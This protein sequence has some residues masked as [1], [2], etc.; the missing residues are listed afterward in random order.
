LTYVFF[1][2]HHIQSI[3]DWTAKFVIKRDECTN[4]HMET[5]IDIQRPEYIEREFSLSFR[6]SNH[7]LLDKDQ[8]W[9]SDEK[10]IIS[11]P[12]RIW[13]EIYD[14]IFVKIISNH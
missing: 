2:S 9:S 10:S 8:L 7:S 11:I 5:Q 6:L 14:L 3:L 12:W 1:F 13:K 4:E